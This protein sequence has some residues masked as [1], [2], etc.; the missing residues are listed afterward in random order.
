MPAP[1]GAELLPL[2]PCLLHGVVPVACTEH[3][4]Q[5]FRHFTLVAV[6]HIAQYIALQMG[7]APLQLRARE[8]LADDILQALKTVRTDQ[9]YPADTAPVQV[10]QHLAPIQGTLRRLVE[11]AENLPG[12]V[13]LHRQ[14]HIKGF[15]IHAALAVDL[16]VD[17]VDEHHRII[18]LQ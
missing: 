4:P 14:N 12:L 17:A 2:A 11:D 18:T 7:G 8:H 3:L 15:R 10:I 6:A 16:D 5:V 13:L 9:A 1:S